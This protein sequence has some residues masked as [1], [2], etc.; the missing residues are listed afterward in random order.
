M[1][2]KNFDEYIEK[3]RRIINSR[4][5]FEN[6]KEVLNSKIEMNTLYI[7]FNSIIDLSE[8]LNEIKELS[9]NSIDESD[10]L[11]T[12]ILSNIESIKLLELVNH[13]YFHIFQTLYQ[14]FKFLHNEVSASHIH[15]KKLG[16]IF[17]SIASS[18]HI[19]QLL[20][21]FVAY[22]DNKSFC[23]ST[24]VSQVNLN[25]FIFE[26]NSQEYSFQNLVL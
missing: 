18:T 10:D 23:L 5:V 15:I 14:V 1:S 13:E 2:I 24:S 20:N 21:S 26:V 16:S 8:R 4:L 25:T 6:G 17:Q 22:F 7:N 11:R 9:N 12:F 19:S 3:Y